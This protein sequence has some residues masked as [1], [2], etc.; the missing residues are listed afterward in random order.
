MKILSIVI[1]S[2]MISSIGF[3]K[4]GQQKNLNK[5]KA[6]SRFDIRVPIKNILKEL[7]DG[8]RVG[9]AQGSLNYNLRSRRGSQ[10][11]QS[12]DQSINEDSRT[13]FQMH[14]GWERVRIKEVGHSIFLTYQ[15]IETKDTQEKTESY[16]N[17]RTSGNITYGLNKQIYTFGGLNYGAWFGTD[18]IESSLD[19][20]FGY[21]LG[22]GFKFH[23]K[24][25]LE[26]EYLTLK[27]EGSKSG[28]NLDLEAKGIMLKLNTP[29][30]FNI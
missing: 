18:E 22:M 5:S 23:K 6:V 28:I 12:L 3:T 11:G 30:S 7:N 21:Q 19:A 24:A 13:K 10:L 1:L 2:L 17:F 27:N 9:V 26:V 29:F 15:D 14:A 25:I 8:F 4:V 20:G 16:R